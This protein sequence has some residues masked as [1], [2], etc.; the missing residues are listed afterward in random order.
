M[1][2]QEWLRSLDFPARFRV[3]TAVVA[4]AGTMVIPVGLAAAG[5]MG[6]AAALAAGG[7]C[8]FSG[9]VALLL[10]E[11]CR[12]PELFLWGVLGGMAIRMVLP[13]GAAALVYYRVEGLANAGFVYY[14]IPFYLIVLATETVLTLPTDTA[15]ARQ[16]ER[17]DEASGDASTPEPPA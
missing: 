10:A 16:A 12:S 8:L 9:L 7:I 3:L 4:L 5:P 1:D 14:L 11:L 6:A 15:P 17:T 2:L 13:L